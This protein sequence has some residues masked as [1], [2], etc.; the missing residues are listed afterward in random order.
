MLR[1]PQPLVALHMYTTRRVTRAAPA[2]AASTASETSEAWRLNLLTSSASIGELATSA[3]RVAV[4]GCKTSERPEQPAYHVA[5][6]LQ[7]QGVVV[8]PVPVYY[9]EVTEILGERVYRSVADVPQPPP[10]DIV[11]VFRRPKDVPAHV[12]DVLA[13][14]PK[15]VWL[16]SGIRCDAAAEEWARAGLQVVQDRCLQ[17]EH[18][19]AK[20][21]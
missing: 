1:A 6:Y 13:A 2:S 5:E 16:Q 21:W 20:R 11:C 10:L 18:A 12:Q 8:V 9:P 17:L 4:L 3:Q 14:R 7:R 15:A 19:R